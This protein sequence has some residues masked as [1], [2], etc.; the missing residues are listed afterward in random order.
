MK[1]LS[2]EKRR[3]MKP[4]GTKPGSCKVHKKFVGDCSLFKPILSALQTPG[5]KLAK[6]LVPILTTNKYKDKDSFN[7]ASEI[8]EQDLVTSWVA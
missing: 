1:I 7:F 6:F 4:V 5:C 8:V 2:E 3:H